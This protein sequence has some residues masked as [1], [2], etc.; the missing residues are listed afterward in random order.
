MKLSEKIGQNKYV[1]RY[2]SDYEYRTVVKTLFSC[3]ATVAVGTYNLLVAVFAGLNGIWLYTLAAYYY[4]LAFA[5][6]AVLF[7][8]RRGLKKGEA[9]ERRRKRGARNY[10]FGGALLVALTLTYSGI[11]VLVTTKG[12]HYNYRGNMIYVMALYAFYKIISSIVY[13]VKYR[14]YRD[15]TV[16]TLR[17]FNIADGIVS[18]IALQSAMLYT[19]SAAEEAASAGMMNAVFGGIAGMAIL[20]LGSYMIVRGARL[21]SSRQ[22]LE[23]GEESPEIAP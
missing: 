23:K 17:N 20:A 1:R 15:Y 6:L 9:E 12:Y 8:H 3:A 19:F 7:S 18:I 2:K 21:L 10:L 13:A 22:Y 16:Q 4:A 5:R 14:K 11:I